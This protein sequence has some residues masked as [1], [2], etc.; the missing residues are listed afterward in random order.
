MG[1]CPSGKEVVCK[2]TQVS[3]TLTLPSKKGFTMTDMTIKEMKAEK[4][5][6]EK[7]ILAQL[8]AFQERTGLYITNIRVQSVAEWTRGEIPLAIEIEVKLV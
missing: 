8:N 1:R 6:L 4:K 2:T 3:S 7:S 5:A